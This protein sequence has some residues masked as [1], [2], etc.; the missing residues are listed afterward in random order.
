MCLPS[1]IHSWCALEELKY[2]RGQSLNGIITRP[3][4]SSSR[5]QTRVVPY[6]QLLARM[7]VLGCLA[8]KCIQK[9]T[10]LEKTQP[11][12]E[13]VTRE[14]GLYCDRPK[15]TNLKRIWVLIMASLKERPE[16][17]GYDKCQPHSGNSTPTS[18]GRGLLRPGHQCNTRF[19]NISARHVFCLTP[20]GAT[21]ALH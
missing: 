18:G 1:D 4:L 8:C 7:C 9:Q 5:L 13:Q 17:I 12:I 16:S 6:E 10:G 20:L 3:Y 11:Y 2:P 19:Q 15:S 14:S 21:P